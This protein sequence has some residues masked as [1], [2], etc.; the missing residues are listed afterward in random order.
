VDAIAFELSVA[1]G[2]VGLSERAVGVT[3]DRTAPIQAGEEGD[4]QVRLSPGETHRWSLS[5]VPHPT[6]NDADTTYLTRDLDPGRYWFGVRLAYEPADGE[7]E[8]TCL[9][10]RAFRVVDGA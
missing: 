3:A 4:D 9:V 2:H 5:R 6:P 7:T 1:T 10:K 8:T